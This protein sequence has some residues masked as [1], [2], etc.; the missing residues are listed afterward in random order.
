MIAY[1]EISSISDLLHT[2]YKQQSLS[3]FRCTKDYYTVTEFAEVVGVSRVTII[4]WL[5]AGILKGELAPPKT[6]KAKRGQWHIYPAGLMQDIKVH[7]EELIEISMKS[8][9]MLLARI[10]K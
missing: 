8:W 1:K 10:K 5:H 9:P 6:K 2:D 4:D 3:N 7:R